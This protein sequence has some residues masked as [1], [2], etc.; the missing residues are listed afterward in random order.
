MSV[1]TDKTV[2]ELAQEFPGAT[3][4]FEKFGIDYC[5]GG[6]SRWRK[7]ADAANLSV[8]EVL[9][10]LETAQKAAQFA[11]EALIG[12][13][14][15][16]PNWSPTSRTRTTSTRARKLHGWALC[17][18]KSARCMGRTIRNWNKCARSFRVWRRNSPCT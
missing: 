3:R 17:L 2:R 12:R 1:A 4:V 15:P 10:S 5:C 9:D 6:K 8:N 14:N 7:L 13:P 11:A 18:Q 16:W